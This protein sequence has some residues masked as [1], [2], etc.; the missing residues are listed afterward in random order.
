MKKLLILFFLFYAI[1]LLSD[2]PATFD[3]RDVDGVNYV[4]SV[5]SQQGGTCWTHGAMAA[6]E[7]NMMMTGA[8]ANAGETGEPNLA[9]YH[10]DWWNG[11]N[12]HNN[13]DVDPPTGTGLVVHEGGDYRVTT[14]YLSRGEG[15]VRDID[16]QSFG[17]APLRDA[18]GYHYY[19]SREVEWFVIEDD[20]SKIDSVKYAIMEHGVLGICMAYD[21]AFIDN[22]FNHYQPPS[23]TME[24]NHA[25]A[26]IGWDDE[27]VTQAP[28]PGAWIVKNSW[29]TDWGYD[30][31]FWISYYDKYCCQHAE[32]GAISFQD[33]EPM[34]YDN[35]YYH[36]YHGWR[37]EFSDGSAVFNKFIAEREEIIRGVNFFT[38]VDNEEFVIV[39]FDNFQ[40]GV[41]A[42]PLG[43]VSGTRKHYGLHTED[44]AEP[45]II[46][47]GDD[48]YVY[49]QFS[50]G[51]YPIDRTS[52]VPVLLGAQYRTIVPSTASPDESYYQVGME[53]LDLYDYAF[54]NELWNHTANF[55]L[56]VLTTDTGLKV[57]PSDDFESFGNP[58]GP[59]EPAQMIYDFENKSL[60]EIEYEVTNSTQE[61]WITIAGDVSGILAAGETAQV[62]IEI[63]ENAEDLPLGTHITEI[64]FVNLTDHTGDTTRNVYLFVGGNS[65]FYEWNMDADPGWTIEADWLWGIPQGLGGQYGEA[66]PVSGYT[67]DNVYGYNLY[68]DY[69]N[70]LDEKHLTT[71]SINCSNL[72]NVN[73]SFWRWLG[74]EQ[75][76]YDHAYV[77]ISNDMET[78]FTLW[79]NEEEIT[80]DEWINM[81][82][83]ISEYADDQETV[84]LRWTMGSTDGGWV[85]CGWNIDDVTITALEGYIT[86]NDNDIINFNFDLYNYPN[87]FNPV[88]DISF[89]LSKKQ[90]V[91][92]TIYNIKGQ[93]VKTLYKGVLPSGIQAVTWN[94]TDADNRQTGAGIYLY[95]LIINGAD[96]STGKC[97]LL[98]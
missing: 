94:G 30:G 79:E 35:V 9:E 12:Q 3:L 50:Q 53:W 85:Y 19:Y 78:W 45:F 44:F 77:K 82:L 14:A 72:Y 7:G 67:G 6:M 80:D 32:M 95:R 36:D 46:N 55:C 76:A 47:E 2:P 88:T 70:N 90:N 75:P 49:L 93:K 8:W 71:K 17:S 38:A 83:D 61:N 26:I 87:P 37:D 74:V 31:Y 54:S 48:F 1:V 65:T 23:S 63:N 5:K 27:H 51:D 39:L 34:Q 57:G 58:G 81:N 66:D 92:L 73:L 86:H 97:I 28:E 4:S 41:L 13:D 40:D 18:P 52:D 91:E 15:A 11:F 59:F 25:I 56:K 42:D 84:Y 16:G 29:D 60:T 62:V 64:Q 68:G 98:K 69:Q 20:L 21:N 24:P 43:E 10:L 96:I 22:Q 89:N 33:V